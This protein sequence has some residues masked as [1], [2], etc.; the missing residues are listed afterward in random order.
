MDWVLRNYD[1]TTSEAQTVD[2]E[3]Q[4]LKTLMSYMILDADRE[5]TFDRLTKMACRV[6]GVPMAYINLVDLGRVFAMASFGAGEERNRF[7]RDTFCAHT[8]LTKEKVFVV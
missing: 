1:A 5:P 8:V 3:L 6:F 7:R 2:H 4:R